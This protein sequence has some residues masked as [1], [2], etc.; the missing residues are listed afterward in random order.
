MSGT[1]MQ[2]QR[3]Q[4]LACL[5]L[6]CCISL[7]VFLSVF[8]KAEKLAIENARTEVAAHEILLR[9]TAEALK[10]NQSALNT[11]RAALDGIVRSQKQ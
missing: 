6:A 8:G 4:A 9:Q 7:A 10:Q 5:V 3:D 1:D 11:T 2:M